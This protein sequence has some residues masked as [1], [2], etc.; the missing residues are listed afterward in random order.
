MSGSPPS[1][2]GRKQS[3]LASGSPRSMARNKSAGSSD[4]A[5]VPDTANLVPRNPFEAQRDRQ[6][7]RDVHTQ[8]SRGAGAQPG[9][10]ASKPGKRTGAQ[11]SGSTCSQSGDLSASQ[12]TKDPY[13]H[14]LL[15]ARLK[16]KGQIA[17]GKLLLSRADSMLK[18]EPKTVSDIDM[19]NE[20]RKRGDYLCKEGTDSALR[21]EQEFLRSYSP[22]MKHF[23]TPAE[24][25]FCTAIQDI[26]KGEAD[27]AKRLEKFRA[28][29]RTLSS[30]STPESDANL[31]CEYVQVIDQELRLIVG[32]PQKP[33]TGNSARRANQGSAVEDSAAGVS[34]PTEGA[35]R[36]A[37][38]SEGSSPS[39][40]RDTQGTF[41]RPAIDAIRRNTSQG[42]PPGR[43]NNNP[44]RMN[45]TLGIP[46]K[47]DAARVAAQIR[48]AGFS[49]AGVG[50]V[51][52]PSANPNARQAIP[53]HPFVSQAVSQHPIASHPI[54]FGPVGVHP[55]GMHA[56][57]S[58][59]LGVASIAGGAPLSTVGGNGTPESVS[60][61][62]ASS[63][64]P[65]RSSHSG[66]SSGAHGPARI[67]SSGGSPAGPGGAFSGSSVSDSSA[68]AAAAAGSPR[69]MDQSGA[70]GGG[71]GRNL[72]SQNPR[73]TG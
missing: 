49:G 65:T 66:S 46:N 64:G 56:T 42:L 14:S 17:Q 15:I 45:T 61:A 38:V 1:P 25:S 31:R 51:N 8:P 59:P 28:R 58:G 12:R 5:V 16:C 39:K 68:A 69:A 19:A 50:H 35:G 54:E 3:Q 2:G 44:A 32:S 63:A 71:S 72:R 27:P 21:L 6:A 22:T 55:A 10:T 13:R 26:L 9:N 47:V 40:R 18:E 7:A 30:G 60:K 29:L 41:E 20:L 23:Y 57:I 48:G 33:T 36:G 73:Q 53:N 11:N 43:P 4:D 52:H 34:G 24:V 70:N 62:G 67:S 37:A